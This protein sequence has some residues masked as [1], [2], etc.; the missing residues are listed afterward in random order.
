MRGKLPARGSTDLRLDLRSELSGSRTGR[1][2]PS[3]S[4]A[5]AETGATSETQ[6]SYFPSQAW[7]GRRDRHPCSSALSSWPKGQTLNGGPNGGRS[8]LP[9][10]GR[11]G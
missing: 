1:E 9:T 11:Q 6:N 4:V 2:R 3:K 7:S 10:A 8:P 5:L